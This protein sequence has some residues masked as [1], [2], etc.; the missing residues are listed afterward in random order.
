MK[1]ISVLPAFLAL[2]LLVVC[3]KTEQPKDTNEQPWA[4]PSSYSMQLDHQ[5]LDNGDLAVNI[6]TNL[7]DGAGILVTV[8]RLYWTKGDTKTYS[9]EFLSEDFVVKEGTVSCITS[10]DDSKWIREYEQKRTDNPQLADV[11]APIRK[12]SDSIQVSAVFSPRRQEKAEILKIVGT[13]GENLTG[14]QVKDLYG[15]IK[16]LEAET[17]FRQHTRAAS[18]GHTAVLGPSAKCPAGTRG[19][20]SCPTP[21]GRRHSARLQAGHIC[22]RGTL[23]RNTW[24]ISGKRQHTWK[25]VNHA[26]FCQFF[27]F[28]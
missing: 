1:K 12:I 8:K 2:M 27:G 18:R 13:K 9:G 16:T 17:A 21:C 11:F 26:V 24:P 4:A 23:G 7:P 20:A 10:L 28:C 19:C 25:R 22:T 3:S 5:Q 14:E 6:A 15:V